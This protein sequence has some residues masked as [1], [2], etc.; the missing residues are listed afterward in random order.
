MRT[1]GRFDRVGSRSTEIRALLGDPAALSDLRHRP[2]RGVIVYR[3][4]GA[5]EDVVYP[6]AAAAA[7]ATPAVENGTFVRWSDAGP[8]GWR[9]RDTQPGRVQGPGSSEAVRIGP[10]RFVYL[11]QSLRADADLR[12]R[13]LTLR[14]DVRSDQP[15]AARLW[16]KVAVG[17]TWEEAFGDPHPGDGAWHPMVAVVPVPATFAGGEARI[18]LLHAQGRGRSEFAN[19]AVAVR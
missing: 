7:S 1:A 16:V 6:L 14:A 9:A 2:D 18:G 10:G 3:L 13:S 5:T 19:V 15:D 11:W 4:T 12:G 17:G 8:A